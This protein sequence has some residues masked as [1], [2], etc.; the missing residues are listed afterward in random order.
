MK[1][2]LLQAVLVALLLGNT[3]Y[4]QKSGLGLGVVVGEPTGISAR[5]W[6]AET[7]AFDAAFAWS[8]SHNA[9]YGQVDYAVEFTQLKVESISLP[10]YGGPGVGV[11][12]ANNPWIGVRFK[13]G[14]MHQFTTY[15]LD[16][17]LEIAP[18][19]G[20]LPDVGFGVGGGLG[21]RYY[22]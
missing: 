5:Y 22:L 12:V 19:L 21:M 13:A 9:I 1:K 11:G 14:I 20:L 15:P 4:A 18:S 2:A 7:H 10:I 3:L 8:L 17:F 6:A 16:L